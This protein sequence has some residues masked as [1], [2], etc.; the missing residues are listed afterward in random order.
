[1]ELILTSAGG[2]PRIGDMPE[3]QILRNTIAGWEKGEKTDRELRAAEDEITK[4]AIKEQINAGLDLITDGLIRW[5]DPVSHI[6]GKME[7]VEISGLHRFFDTNFYF[8]QPVINGTIRRRRPIIVDEFLFAKAVSENPVKPV[9]TGP[10]TLAKLSDTGSASYAALYKTTENFA[11]EI[12]KEIKELSEAGAEIIQIDEPA[13]LKY[14]GDYQIFKEAI[15]AL[16]SVKGNSKL[17]LYTY[18]GDAAPLYDKFQT[19]PV[20]ILG[21][22]F[23]YGR[24]LAEIISER[25]SIKPLGLGLID[26]RNTKP[27][28]RKQIIRILDRVI[29][30]IKSGV[31]YLNPSCGLEYLPRDKAFEKLR[32]MSTIRKEFLKS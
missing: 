11:L 17:A 31:S 30:R 20:D 29:P 16:N 32:S 6:A 14:P 21:M 5:Y 27:E 13:I 19:L 24:E 3:E 25:G 18:F 28:S 12:L 23:T 26:G 8:R 9:I 2:Y 10:Y 7:G 1:M 22:D 15:L 4:R